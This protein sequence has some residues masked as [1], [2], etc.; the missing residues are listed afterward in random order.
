MDQEEAERGDMHIYKIYDK[1]DIA[2]ERR[3]GWILINE[4]AHE[5]ITVCF[6]LL[7]V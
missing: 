3:E 4:A 6:F 2:E 7:H 5:K 1:N